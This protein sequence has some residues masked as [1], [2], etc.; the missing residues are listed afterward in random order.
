[1]VKDDSMRISHAH[2]F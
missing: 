1:M 2:G